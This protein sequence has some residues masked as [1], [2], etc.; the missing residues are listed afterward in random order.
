MNTPISERI[1]RRFSFVLKD[2]T[3]LFPIRMKRRANGRVSFRVSP[4]GTGGNTLA[5]GQ[6]VDEETMVALVLG[7]GFSVRCTS[8]DGETK[9]LYK[10][11]GRSV[12][13]V[14]RLSA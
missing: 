8:L 9:G 14:R 4:G 12:R 7:N 13:E 1:S 5:A 6:E 3:E 10:A 11:C 2:G